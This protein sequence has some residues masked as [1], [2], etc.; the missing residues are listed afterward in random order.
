[1][2]IL[3]SS[4]GFLFAKAGWMQSKVGRLSASRRSLLAFGNQEWLSLSAQRP[5]LLARARL[6]R[7]SI[8]RSG[9]QML[10]F[11]YMTGIR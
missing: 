8:T 2:Q 7:A 3:V 11:H 6:G 1:M 9:F 4:Y 10:S 5:C